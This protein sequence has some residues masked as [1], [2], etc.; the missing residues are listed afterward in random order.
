ML[1]KLQPAASSKQQV[2]NITVEPDID[3]FNNEEDREEVEEEQEI[4]E[5]EEEEGEQRREPNHL[6]SDV[7]QSVFLS[8]AIMTCKATLT[9]LD[10]QIMSL[11]SVNI[12][13]IF[14]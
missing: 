14:I 11:R 13:I 12:Y 8:S 2:T 6:A 1:K 9:A 7:Q 3:A 10:T 4:E 5:E